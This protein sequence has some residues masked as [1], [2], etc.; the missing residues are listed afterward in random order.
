MRR[1]AMAAVLIWLAMASTVSP[2]L[3]AGKVL[4]SND[5][6]PLSDYGYQRAPDAARFALNVADFFTGGG[7]PGRF[8]VYSTNHGL[9][10][11]RLAA[12]M[13]G[14]GHSWTI[15]DPDTAPDE[16]FTPY[17]AVFV[18]QNFV[19]AHR[20][21]DYVNGGGN[22]YV[23]S[24]TGFGAVDIGWN[25]FLSA[26]GLAIA[27]RSNGLSG[28][29]AIQSAHPL[30]ACVHSLFMIAGNSVSVDNTYPGGMVVARA[31]GQGLFGAFTAIT[32]PMEIRTAACSDDVSLRRGSA[33]TLNVTLYGNAE[34]ASSSVDLST[35]KLLD[36][37]PATGRVA[38]VLAGV[39]A[40]VIQ[41]VL[42][43]F[44]GEPLRFDARK[45]A[46]TIWQE[47]GNTI[48]DGEVVLLT[49]SGRLKP[50]H[51]GTAIRA[52]DTVILRTR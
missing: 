33:G 30:F 50:E 51:G 35:V 32:L 15:K 17:D 6:W 10:G 3:A 20:L 38:E 37:R 9:T 22:V 31:G 43:G 18:G 29:V 1:T 28:A 5:E 48:D 19:A 13:T 44:A 36:V 34:A 45:V 12:T 49:L 40:I 47:L 14:A 16:D 52:H 39:G 42:D 46:T 25:A 11:T 27:S 21:T 23:V 4:V 2:A 8:L 24:G 41:G 26:F 7:R